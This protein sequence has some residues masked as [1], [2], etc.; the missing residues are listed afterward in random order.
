V[1]TKSNELIQKGQIVL[2]VIITSLFFAWGLAA[3]MT[4][5]LLAAFKRIMSMSDYQTT[6]VQYAFYG[7]YFFFALPAA[8]LITRFSYKIGILIGLATYI[9]GALMFFPAS[10]TMVYG[11]FLLA[12]YVLAAGLAFLETSANPFIYKL[13]PEETATRRLNLAQSFNPIGAIF[14][15]LLSKF[16]ILSNLNEADAEARSLMSAAELEAIQSQELAGVMGPYVGVAIVLILLWILIAVRAFPENISKEASVRPV[17]SLKRLIKKPNYVGAV[18]AQFIYVGAQVCVW[19]FTI[20]YTM[21]NLDVNEASA[22]SYYTAALVAF[23]FSRFV[24]T[25]AMGYIKPVKLLTILAIL[26]ALLTGFAANSHSIA[27]V[28]ALIA[29]SACMSLMFPTIYGI[30]L[31]GLGEDAKIGAAGLV[32]AIIGGAVI[33]GIQGRVSDL[34]G[35]M[36]ASFY[37][38]M[39]CFLIIAL[40]AF[41]AKDGKS[42][43]SAA[44]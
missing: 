18:F 19:S 4:D 23:L 13:G 12:L 1:E 2:F 22:A 39:V 14:G 10:K 11:H 40:Y 7:S 9:V 36:H 21:A 34:T 25:W 44:A 35:S 37:V 27:G 42:E 38:P 20:R 31:K 3:N 33:T 24:C 15:V 17:S 28:Y 8:L 43:A 41:L 30:G 29:V 16:F 26:A 32:M 6:F 5:T